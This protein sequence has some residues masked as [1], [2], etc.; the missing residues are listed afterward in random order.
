MTDNSST[1]SIADK[2][3][4][5]KSGSSLNNV[6]APSLEIGGTGLWHTA[7]VI[8]EDFLQALVWPKAT[9]TYKEMSRNDPIISASLTAIEM[10]IRQAEWNVVPADESEEAGR[11]AEFLRECME[12]MEKPWMEV[13][14]DILS[15]LP[16]GFSIQEL[17]YKRRRGLNTRDLRFRSKFND[18]RWGWRKLPT[19]AQDTVRQWNLSPKGELE[20][21]IQQL[22]NSFETIE[23]PRN[24][25]LLFRVNSRKDNPES[26]SI[27]RGAYRPWV[28]KKK[29]EEF[30][31]IGVERDLAG[32]P[33][34]YI[35]AEYM[36]DE[37]TDDQKAFY[38]KVKKIV[39]SVRNNEQAGL[40]WPSD[41]DENGNQMFKFEL[42]GKTG[43]GGKTYDTEKIIQRYN[44][45]IAQ[46]M[47]ADFILL[48]QKSVGSFALS[49]NKTELFSVALGAWLDVISDVF[50]CHAIPQLMTLNNVDPALWPKLE[51]GD[52]ETVDIE[53]L[54]NYFGELADK[55]LL[56]PDNELENWFRKQ[57]NAP[58]RTSESEDVVGV[59]ERIKNKQIE[60][61]EKIAENSNQEDPQQIEGRQP[62]SPE[63]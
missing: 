35:P 42:L 57:V 11:E 23:I 8:D 63:S 60:S 14:N 56:A 34:A 26:V 47:L 43:Q 54:G 22:P 25:F 7:G 3:A 27:L 40:V 41:T 16:F 30:E 49:D 44:A 13:I 1:D 20:G 9:S 58:L 4:V 45:N 2:N 52:V 28:F 48:G 46:T 36:S 32:L 10:L 24:K 31:A 62:K 18:G 19:R 33:I 51:H 55:G 38:N 6:S 5:V 12:D 50:N 61:S 53:K 39:T 17:V 37:A 59:E 21:F 15:F 29:I